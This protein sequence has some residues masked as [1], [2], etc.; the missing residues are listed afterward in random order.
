VSSISTIS[1][2]LP[3]VEIIPTIDISNATQNHTS[4][5][6]HKITKHTN[7]TTTNETTITNTTITIIKNNGT[8]NVTK[9]STHTSIIFF[10][11]KKFIQQKD[12]SFIDVEANKTV[13][14]NMDELKKYAESLF[15]NVKEKIDKPLPPHANLTDVVEIKPIELP[16]LNQT[17]KNET[18]HEEVKAK[19]EKLG[20]ET[21]NTTTITN[22]THID[23]ET[24]IVNNTVTQ[25]ITNVE[26]SS[27]EDSEKETVK[28][29]VP[30]IDISTDEGNDD[31]D[32]D[33]ILGMD[34]KEDGDDLI[35]LKP[36]E[37]VGPL[38]VTNKTTTKSQNS[39]IEI[40]DDG[41][42]VETVTKLVN[43]TKALKNESQVQQIGNPL[44]HVAIGDST[45][46]IE[47]MKNGSYALEGEIIAENKTELKRW[48]KEKT[49]ELVPK[50]ELGNPLVN[51]DI[52]GEVYTFEELK[53]GSYSLDGEIVAEDKKGFNEWISAKM[54]ATAP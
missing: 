2:G 38:V 8:K 25:V 5:V 45:F 21:A 19:V 54:N 1:Q 3:E 43:E 23:N 37:T 20:N 34:T 24:T 41:S 27:T 7:G 46:S 18:D 42:E 12:G 47:E 50:Q 30:D 51:V 28:T 48:V 17:H 9:P 39:T 14:K 11:D 13:A 36:A 26:P 10:G 32:I 35:D 52:N 31:F 29:E 49:E 33:S 15:E 16:N 44:M 22:M 53:N 6:T 4:N 40:K